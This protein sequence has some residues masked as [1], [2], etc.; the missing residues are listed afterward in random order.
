MDEGQARKGSPFC[1]W[2]N[3]HVLPSLSDWSREFLDEECGAK[4]T[5]NSRQQ[6]VLDRAI[7]I[8]EDIKPPSLAVQYQNGKNPTNMYRGNHGDKCVL[9]KLV[10]VVGVTDSPAYSVSLGI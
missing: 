7:E 8:H 4:D 5:L 6:L 9:P 3:R 2:N 1:G 10:H